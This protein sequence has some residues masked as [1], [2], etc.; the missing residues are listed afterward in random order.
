MLTVVLDKLLTFKVS[1]LLM[2]DLDLQNER[3]RRQKSKDSSRSDGVLSEF[4]PIFFFEKCQVYRK[5]KWLKVT[6]IYSS[7]LD[8]PIVNILLN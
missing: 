2:K 7:H 6:S 8:L 3:F 5:D 4:S 1:I